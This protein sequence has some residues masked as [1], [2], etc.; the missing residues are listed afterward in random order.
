[1][2]SGCSLK[3]LACFGEFDLDRVLGGLGGRNTKKCAGLG[4]SSKFT[5]PLP[6]QGQRAAD[7]LT[8][9]RDWSI[10]L[11]AQ[12]DPFGPNL[13]SFRGR[14]ARHKQDLLKRVEIETRTLLESTR[15]Q[16]LRLEKADQAGVRSPCFGQ[17]VVRVT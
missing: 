6:V 12:G 15:K 16:A 14:T 17:K 10:G 7:R 9:L 2:V 4:L 1:V 5:F 11:F 3:P 13:G 8:E